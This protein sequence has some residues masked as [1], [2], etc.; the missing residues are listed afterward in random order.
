MIDAIDH[1]VL[2]CKNLD[3]T[4]NFYCNILGM[5]LE[6]NYLDNN[7]QIC[8]KFGSQ[9][10][11]LHVEKDLFK[12]HAGNPV[13]GSVDVCF[14]SS[15][16]LNDWKVILKRNNVEIEMGPVKRDGA[17]N[18]IMSIYFRDPDQ[19]LIEIANKIK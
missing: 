12:P 14:L 15:V 19:N 17:K 18:A 6:K 7:V 16:S 13:V 4:V 9:K 3:R 2:T 10:I 8:L 5:K 1:I 11:N